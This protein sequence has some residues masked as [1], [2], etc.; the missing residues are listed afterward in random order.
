M[1]K[2]T[3]FTTVPSRYHRTILPSSSFPLFSRLRRNHIPLYSRADNLSFSN[4]PLSSFSTT[5]VP[6]SL[7]VDNYGS[8]QPF[9]R[10][11]TPLRPAPL[12][13]F[14][15]SS[16]HKRSRSLME[17][18]NK[19]SLIPSFR[20]FSS[21][22]VVHTSTEVTVSSFSSSSTP[23]NS[24]ASPNSSSSSSSSNSSSS[25]TFKT[26]G[27]P[28]HLWGRLGLMK[29]QQPTPVQIATLPSLC[30]N[31]SLPPSDTII[32]AETGSGKTLCYLLPIL[33][34]LEP[35]IVPYSRLRAII[36]TPTRELSLQVFQIAEFLGQVGNKK[37]P[38]KT[39]KVRRIVGEINAQVLYELK[40]NPPHILV[41]T[42]A[43]L[44]KL[45]PTHLNTGELQTLVLDEVDE[46]LR[47]HSIIHVKSLISS[48]RKHGNN[49]GIIAVSAT[50]SFS[51]QKLTTESLHRQVQTIDL[52]EGIMSTPSTLSH[53][54]LKLPSAES[55]YNTF[56]RFLAAARPTGV[57]LAFHNSAASLEALEVHLRSKNIPVA[58][59][60]NAYT[61]SQR[62]QALEGV[63][64]GRIKV[65]LSTEMAARGLDLP[66]ISHV[67]NFDPAESIREYVHRAGRT[68]R[69]SSLTPGRKG[70]VITFVLNDKE[71]EQMIDNAR[72]LGV[73][74]D[75]MMI[76][77]GEIRTHSLLQF[78]ANRA[79]HVARI[80][81]DQEQKFKVR[82][83]TA[84]GTGVSSTLAVSPPEEETTK[85]P[86]KKTMETS[87]AAEGTVMKD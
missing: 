85:I 46:L 50:S 11:P 69:L 43:S 71:A 27:I 48:V 40:E 51:L 39:V 47:N 10:S 86:K 25:P 26:L 52:T 7:L 77:N 28:S 60:G 23:S 35:K 55:A 31:L 82:R 76:E 1:T 6:F 38:N 65:L 20:T 9:L 5:V 15:P 21:S 75:D 41:G 63:R 44:A 32:H 14:R 81:K 72:S 4:T 12:R 73:S 17:N 16:T 79:D 29:I 19:V 68:G 34:R 80:R 66:R 37:D 33:A 18:G 59:L 54:V 22:S 84:K 67:V 57:V 70:I 78:T 30:Y 42:P 49:P 87:T 62:A 61:N 45:L 53:Y 13:I 58:V 83:G 2:F 8:T 56:T 74:L 64:N 36:V 24:S 3:S